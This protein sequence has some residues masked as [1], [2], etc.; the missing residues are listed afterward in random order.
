MV[1]A[2]SLSLTLVSLLLT[3]CATVKQYTERA[4]TEPFCYP[5]AKLD[6]HKREIYGGISCR[7]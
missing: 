6:R 2:V 5:K 3:G 1:R 4:Y 7:F